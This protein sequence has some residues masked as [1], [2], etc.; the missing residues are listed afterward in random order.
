MKKTKLFA[1]LALAATP[2][3]LHAQTTNYSDIVGYQTIP[4]PANTVTAVGVNFLNP[5]LIVGPISSVSSSSVSVSGVNDLTSILST[6]TPYYLE[7]LS[8]VNEGTRLEV[9]TSA[10]LTNCPAIYIDTSSSRNTEVLADISSSLTNATVA[11]RRHVTLSTITPSIVGLNS[12][13]S[14][15]GD[16]VLLFNSATSSWVTYLRR[17][18]TTWRDIF[19]ATVD[20]VIPP[21]EG[22]LI[23]KRATA[24]NLSIN[25]GVRKNNFH[26]N[27]KSGYQF[28]TFGFPVDNSF[29]S[30]GAFGGNWKFGTA[31]TGDEALILKSDGSGYD[32]YLYRTSTTWRDVFNVT[33]NTNQILSGGGAVIFKKSLAEDLTLSKPSGL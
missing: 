9:D 20:P 2:A 33:V 17:T 32:S 5:D 8:G 10:S 7:V 27:T 14:G 1:V 23:R 25:G 13:A 18:S 21:G 19:N 16:E 15:T 3:F 11:L 6:N 26:L 28:L 31:G 24:G 30:V 22:I 4:L 12:G 29:A